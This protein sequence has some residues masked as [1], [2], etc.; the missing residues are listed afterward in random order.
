MHFIIMNFT[1]NPSEADRQS[2][3][4][5]SHEDTPEACPL[6]HSEYSDWRNS[7][8]IANVLEMDIEQSEP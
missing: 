8:K 7:W 6:S 4:L 2:C 3:W 1:Y 5:E